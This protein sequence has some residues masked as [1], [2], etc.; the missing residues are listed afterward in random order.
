MLQH[1]KAMISR[2]HKIQL[3]SM[4]LALDHELWDYVRDDGGDGQTLGTC[5]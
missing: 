4:T 1:K 3:E 2:Y 5:C